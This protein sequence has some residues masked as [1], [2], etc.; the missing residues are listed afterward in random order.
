MEVQDFPFSDESKGLIITRSTS[1]NFLWTECAYIV[2]TYNETYLVADNLVE[3]DKVQGKYSSA[4]YGR[5]LNKSLW[6]TLKNTSLSESYE[7]PKGVDQTHG[8][9]LELV[10]EL[11]EVMKPKTVWEAFKA[12]IAKPFD[13]ID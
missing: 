1:H 9:A 4:W 2:E 3:I 11:D 12:W 5:N 7:K 8:R 10:R 13:E 6:F